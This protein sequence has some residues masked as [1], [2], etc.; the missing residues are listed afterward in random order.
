M[1]WGKQSL[2]PQ[3]L[4]EE[5]GEGLAIEMKGIILGLIRSGD[6]IDNKRQNE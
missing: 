2:S 4:A 5:G 6:N 3:P 1:G